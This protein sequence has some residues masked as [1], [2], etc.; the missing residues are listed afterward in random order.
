[1]Y[2]WPSFGVVRQQRIY[3]KDVEN[4]T[5]HKSLVL[6]VSQPARLSP[7][8]HEPQWVELKSDTSIACPEIGIKAIYNISFVL[9]RL[10]MWRHSNGRLW[11]NCTTFKKLLC[12]PYLVLT[13]LLQLMAWCHQGQYSI[14]PEI[15]WAN[16]DTSPCRYIVLL[17]GWVNLSHFKDA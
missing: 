12:S 4:A 2:G 6:T 16:V 9:F 14:T 15:T 1:M 7:G 3:W 10:I 5:S 11:R 8:T 17:A 13:T